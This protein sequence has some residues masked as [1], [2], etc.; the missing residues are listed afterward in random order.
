MKDNQEIL[1]LALSNTT[2][3]M[4]MYCLTWE[5]YLE[6]LKKTGA[7]TLI[8][9]LTNLYREVEKDSLVNQIDKDV[10]LQT[11]LDRT[12]VVS[13]MEQHILTGIPYSIIMS[14]YAC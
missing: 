14:N 5:K 4:S 6:L 9:A 12:I 10:L 8:G 7:D 3:Y 2:A 11:C 13:L 1:A